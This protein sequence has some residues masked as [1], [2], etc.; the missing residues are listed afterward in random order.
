MQP[1]PETFKQLILS[2]YPDGVASD[3]TPY[4]KMDATTLTQ[5]VVAN[6]PDG[7]TNA[8]IKYSDYLTSPTQP[9]SSDTSDKSLFVKSSTPDPISGQLG[10]VINWSGIGNALSSSAKQVGYDITAGSRAKSELEN[11]KV[12]QDSQFNTEK[13]LQDQINATKLAG[14][15]TT[16]LQ[17]ILDTVKKNSIAPTANT[18]QQNVPESGRTTLQGL[19]DV[20]GLGLDALS[21][22]TY[23]EAAKAAETGKLLTS[24][25]KLANVATKAGIQTTKPLVEQA[26]KPT[27]AQLLTQGVKQTP[28]VVGL[29]EAYNTDQNLQQGLTGKETLTKNAGT[30]AVLAGALHLGVAG[31]GA[32]ISSIKDLVSPSEE[33][34][35]NARN[36]I[37]ESYQKTLPLTPTQQTKEANLLQKTG[38]NVY[39]TLAKNNIN[40]GSDKAPGQLQKVSDQ[41]EAATNAAKANEYGYFN[42]DEIKANAAK[43]IDET[44][45]SETS[46]QTA[47]NKINAEVDALVKANPNSVITDVN[48][49]TKVNS[50]LVERLRKTGNSWTPFNASDPEK[51]GQ[52]AGY[53]L[54]NATRDQ[55]EKEGT[56]PA[57]RE[58]NK[59]W[60]KVL[61]AQEVLGKIE[62]SGKSFKV[63]G[64]LSGAISRR[65]LSGALGFHTAGLGGAILAEV[66]SEYGAKIMANP[67]LRTW[68]NRKIVEN[69]G[70]KQTPEVIQ[71]LSKEVSDYI[72]QSESR[73]KLPAPRPVGSAE[74][75][76]LMPSAKSPTTYEPAAQKINRQKGLDQLLLPS[77]K[78]GAIAGETVRLPVKSQLTLDTLERNNPNI[79]TPTTPKKNVPFLPKPG[80]T[81]YRMPMQPKGTAQS[82]YE[83]LLGLNTV[84]NAKIKRD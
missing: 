67:E 56:F 39:T 36:K 71:R 12:L 13:S 83:E 65:V 70:E 82:K 68:F 48:G 78:K 61:H 34:V 24:S 77:G 20:A 32:A 18:F 69:A 6:H 4:A 2:K 17:S 57:Y 75:P 55:V 49:D 76:H 16:H 64:G 8:G 14:K 45:P 19:G 29:G 10:N 5:K 7:V 15:D 33:A 9:T 1:N 25:Q 35:T 3:G 37:A 46:R 41:F 62:D 59:E 60:G 66:G 26:V 42:V 80:Q 40:L 72:N 73:L 74:N 44:V 58:A 84:K 28:K 63:P 54:A 50:D 47:K 31:G 21:S 53:A 22:G 23:G 52:S 11:E 79:K 30:A 81:S 51:V 43:H 38:D 27:V